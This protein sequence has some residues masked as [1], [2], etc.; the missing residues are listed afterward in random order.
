MSSKGG[1]ALGRAVAGRVGDYRASIFLLSMP[2][3]V[4]VV[5]AAAPPCQNVM[6][7]GE[8]RINSVH[9]AEAHSLPLILKHL[10]HTDN[11]NGASR[12]LNCLFWAA[13]P[14]AYCSA[15]V[16]W[17][18]FTCRLYACFEEKEFS[19]VSWERHNVK[20]QRAPVVLLAGIGG[21]V[22]AGGEGAS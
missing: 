12:K 19:G 20:G 13:V 14:V 4:R 5:V 7:L 16:R 2:E 3:L 15:D 10:L 22:G 11:S 21:V 17:R 18:L 8:E 1:R 6:I 9:R